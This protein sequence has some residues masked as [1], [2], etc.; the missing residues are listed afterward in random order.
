MDA[1]PRLDETPPPLPHAALAPRLRALLEV[2]ACSGYPSQILIG[3]L[4]SLLGFG[5]SSANGLPTLRTLSVLL[6][7]DSIVI[8]SLALWFLRAGGESPRTVLFGDRDWTIEAVLGMLLVPTLLALVVL[9]GLAIV[10]FAPWLRPPQNPLAGLMTSPHDVFVLALVGLVA[11]GVR[12]EVQR[13][14][15]LHRFEQHLGGA[16]TGLVSF[17]LLFGIGHALQGWAAVITTT[18]LGAFWG[19]IYLRRR[20]IVAPM[21]S[22]SGFNLVQTALLRLQV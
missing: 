18:I 1:D 10:K 9:L 6:A 20:S 15:I 21:V 3:L 12:E 17:S 4:I 5:S 13:A 22:H 11:G 19:V 8:V 14:F 16:M 2:A 7:L